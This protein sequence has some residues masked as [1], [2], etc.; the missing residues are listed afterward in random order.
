MICTKN[1]ICSLTKY[2]QRVYTK[3]PIKVFGI[4]VK[5]QK[6]QNEN[7]KSAHQKINNFN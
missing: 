6:K 2:L 5:P 1:S 3:A 4:K 7:L